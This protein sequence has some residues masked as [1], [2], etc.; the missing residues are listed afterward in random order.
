MHLRVLGVS[1]VAAACLVSP[2]L[3]ATVDLKVTVWPKGKES[4]HAVTWSLRC[5]PA[6]GT[7]PRPGQA[8]RALR[9]LRDPFALIP[10]SEIC[11]QIYGGPQVALVHGTFRG[12]RV[13]ASFKRTDGCQVAR[14][15]R[16]AFLFPAG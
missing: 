2:S 14:W 4:G 6:G 7:L 13:W 12:R 1:L 8:C 15:N 10:P 5:T 3:A 9:A 11:T 16:L